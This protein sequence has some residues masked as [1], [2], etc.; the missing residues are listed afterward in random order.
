M[1]LGLFCLRAYLGWLSLSSGWNM[2]LRVL[3]DI[4]TAQVGFGY[5][6]FTAAIAFVASFTVIDADFSARLRS[7]FRMS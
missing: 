1:M 7:S 5:L 3:K 6:G 4:W 2:F